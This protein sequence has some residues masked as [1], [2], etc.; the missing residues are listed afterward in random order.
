MQMQM[1]QLAQM[2]P[3]E[4]GA[5][6]AQMQAMQAQ[7]A[8]VRVF[9][10]VNTVD[11]L[12]ETVRAVGADGDLIEAL[13][14]NTRMQRG[15]RNSDYGMTFGDFVAHHLDAVTPRATLLVLGDARTNSTNPRYDALRTIVDEA[16][17]AF[18]LN[19]EA[20]SQWGTGDSVATKYAEI[21]DMHEC[22]TITDLRDSVPQFPTF[23]EGYL[24]ALDALDA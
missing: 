8:R 1:Q 15:H 23:N 20:E 21:I 19:P 11:E 17:H 3:V 6:V 9:G 18:W 22:R 24:I 10:F 2:T 16:R 7:F 13:R 5:K 4:R 12:T 14:G